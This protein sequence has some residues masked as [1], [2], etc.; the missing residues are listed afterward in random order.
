MDIKTLRL[1]TDY[2]RKTNAQ[3]NAILQKLEFSQW[4]QEFKGYFTSIKSL[5]NHI[6]LADFNWLKRFSKLRKFSYI[7]NPLFNQELRFGSTVFETIGEYLEKRRI[8][9]DQIGRVRK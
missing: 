4:N 9:D 7:E 8:L 2:N 6:Y 3:M 1:F 5:C